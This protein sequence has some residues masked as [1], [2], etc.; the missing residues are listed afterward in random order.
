METSTQ[1]RHLAE[2]VGVTIGVLIIYCLGTHLPL[3]GL[4]PEKLTQIASA[5]SSL[6]RVSIFAIG[7]T[8]LVTVLIVAELFKT[9]FPDARRWEQAKPRNAAVL[10]G[11]LIALALVLSA[12]DAAGHAATLETISGLVLDPGSWFLVQSTIT[13]VA[14]TAV[15]IVL[16]RAIDRYGIGYGVWLIYLA[17]A[18][19]QL[20]HHVATIVN[21][22]SV[23]NVD[24]R[25]VLTAAYPVVAI[26]ALVTLLLADSSRRQVGH[27]LLW[28]MLIGALL[29]SWAID[30][31]VVMGGT[32]AAIMVANTGILFAVVVALATYL[33]AR[34]IRLAG[35]PLP[36]TALP[37]GIVL[38]CMALA[39]ELLPTYL[40]VVL[41][42]IST[43]LVII[44]VVATGIL[45]DWNI[46]SQR[47][48]ADGEQTEL[49]GGSGG[50]S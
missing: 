33:Y 41:P 13:L 34:S 35:T 24:L 11:N 19:S 21:A 17:P 26:A 31:I 3:P 39:N 42:L 50:A 38:V 43:D 30:A 46:V 48:A 47:V 44:A 45:F 40:G 15:L 36:W 12:I 10:A 20:P 28:P 7:I 23:I 27:A 49:L 9:L 6:T 32:S 29:T 2:R 22:Y 8:P 1:G 4:D 14:A 37:I 16:A 18:L 25:G 5:E